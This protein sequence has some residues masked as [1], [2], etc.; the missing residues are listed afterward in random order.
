[1]MLIKVDLDDTPGGEGSFINTDHIIAILP[2]FRNDG[3]WLVLAKNDCFQGSV[4]CK[5]SAVEIVQR[6][7]G[8]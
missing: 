5:Q 6:I 4:K 2:G 8:L 3:S 7:R 1:M